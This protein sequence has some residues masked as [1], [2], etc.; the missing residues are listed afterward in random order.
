MNL[1]PGYALTIHSWESDADNPREQVLYGLKKGD[2][3]FYIALLKQFAPHWDGGFGN[4]EVRKL[5]PL[6]PV[7]RAYNE[8]APESKLLKRDVI[9]NIDSGDWCHGFLQDVIDSWG[10]GEFWRV[11]ERAEV[12]YIT[13]KCKDCTSEFIS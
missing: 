13:V 7:M 2:V 8:C 12:Y 6:I 1:D 10:E 11:F 3:K 5:D 9:D 4:T